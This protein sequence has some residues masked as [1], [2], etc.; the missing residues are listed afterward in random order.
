MHLYRLL[1]THNEELDRSY[2]L[3]EALSLTLV[4]KCCILSFNTSTKKNLCSGSMHCPSLSEVLSL[5]KQLSAYGGCEKGLQ[6]NVVAIGIVLLGSGKKATVV[7]KLS[8]CYGSVL[9]LSPVVKHQHVYLHGN[10]SRKVLYDHS[11]SQEDTHANLPGQLCDEISPLHQGS[12]SLESFTKDSQNTIPLPKSLENCDK[13][14]LDDRSLP[15]QQSMF[16]ASSHKHIISSSSVLLSAEDGSKC[17]NLISSCD[18]EC[19]QYIAELVKNSELIKELESD[20]E[21]SQVERE[22]PLSKHC[23]F[24]NQL[25]CSDLSSPCQQTSF[26]RENCSRELI[27]SFS[28]SGSVSNVCVGVQRIPH[29]I[30]KQHGY[31]ESEFTVFP[32]STLSLAVNSSGISD[33][34]SPELFSP[35]SDLH[36]G[37]AHLTASF[38]TNQSQTQLTEGPCASPDLFGSTLTDSSDRNTVS[39]PI[40]VR[41]SQHQC[42]TDYQTP[43]LPFRTKSHVPRRKLVERKNRGMLRDSQLTPFSQSKNFPTSPTASHHLQLLMEDCPVYTGVCSKFNFSPDLF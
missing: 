5:N 2:L 33:S 7:S 41:L 20:W 32:S 26:Y 10:S 28:Q 9:G 17:P 14:Q 4:G 12:L 16:E 30:D 24:F 34:L 21:S 43:A 29:A 40:P 31:A 19:L 15:N 37:G 39:E 18:Q 42:S 36:H 1:N 25:S 27:G 35:A 23:S 3:T 22:L 8:H 11:N 6:L 38:A 13:T